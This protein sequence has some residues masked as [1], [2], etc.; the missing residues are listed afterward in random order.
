[1]ESLYVYVKNEFVDEILKYGMKLSENANKVLSFCDTTKRG[2]IGYLSP[3]DTPLYLDES[4]T[5]LR[6]N[7]L[8]LNIFIFNLICE[9]TEHFNKFICKINE[10]ILG[11]Y[12]EPTALICS[13][14]LPENIFLYNKILDLPLIVENSKQFFYEKAIGDM[15]ETGKF[16]NFELYQLLLILGEQKNIFDIVYSNDK[17]KLYKDK[18]SKKTYTKKSSF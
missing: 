17:L 7:V 5:C 15:L 8:D 9:N 1:M 14:I 3:K 16:A 4:Y 18:I 2:I 12:E 10:Y 11:D 13:S 6:I